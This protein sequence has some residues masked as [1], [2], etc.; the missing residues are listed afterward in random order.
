MVAVLPS[1]KNVRLEFRYD[2]QGR[3]VEKAVYDR[4]TD[5]VTSLQRF[6]YEGWNLVGTL[7]VEGEGEQQVAILNTRYV[8]RTGS[9]DTGSFGLLMVAGDHDGD[10]TNL[11]RAYYPGYDG[12]GNLTSLAENRQGVAAAAWEYSPFGE[13]LRAEASAELPSPRSLGATFG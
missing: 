8:W 3:R 12:R 9:A 11:P 13:V 10:P 5:E 4:S 7:D 1:E 2:E 6:I